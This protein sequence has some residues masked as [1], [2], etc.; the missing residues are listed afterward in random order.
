MEVRLQSQGRLEQ[1]LLSVLDGCL[2]LQVMLEPAGV[3]LFGQNLTQMT[4]MSI[5]S[6]FYMTAGASSSCREELEMLTSY[7]FHQGDSWI[8]DSTVL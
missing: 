5:R 4:H 8:L 2:G 7:S 1:Q 6:H 3:L